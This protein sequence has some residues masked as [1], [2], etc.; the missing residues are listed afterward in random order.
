MVMRSEAYLGKPEGVSACHHT[1]TPTPRTPPLGYVQPHLTSHACW[2]RGTLRH[3]ARLSGSGF[4][5]AVEIL[6]RSLQASTTPMLWIRAWGA[7]PQR[8][9]PLASRAASMCPQPDPGHRL[10]SWSVAHHQAEEGTA[11]L[12]AFGP[13]S[14]APSSP[15][16]STGE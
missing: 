11:H 16:K 13:G 5:A 10:P 8:P 3:G 9:N 15:F 12:P 1:D 2:A 6:P 7:T 14:P 4:Q